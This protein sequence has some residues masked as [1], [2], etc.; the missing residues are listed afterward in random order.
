M[1]SRRIRSPISALMAM[2]VLG[3]TSCGSTNPYGMVEITGK[4]TYEDGTPLPET[5]QVKF[6]PMVEA[7]DAKT[8]P[9][10]GNTTTNADGT[11]GAVT[12][13]KWGDGLIQGKHK[14]VLATEIAGQAPKGVPP[15]YARP[16]ET[17]LVV[18]TSE[19]PMHIKISKP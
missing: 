3:L 19:L 17:P 12:T 6:L 4:V 11:F 7:I 5:V 14:V 18:D 16:G 2:A 10:P 9:R 8:Q 15:K 13:H 1:L